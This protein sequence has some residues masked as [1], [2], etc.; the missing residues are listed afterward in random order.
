[1]WG[2]DVVAWFGAGAQLALGGVFLWAALSKTLALK[3]LREAIGGLGAPAGVTR[4]AA[5]AVV[6]VE[7]LTGVGLLLVPGSSVP[8][9]VV[10]LL[11]VGFAA[12]GGT[13]IVTKRRIAC[14]CFGSLGRGMLGRRQLAQFPLWLGLAGIA[15]WGTPVWSRTDGLL[16]LAFVLF[17]MCAVRLPGLLKPIRKLRADRIALAPSYQGTRPDDLPLPEK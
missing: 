15:E 6:A 5:P 11:A 10:V 14:N 3:G 16:V 13:A 7:C 8:R 4:L 1:M 12:A 2:T 17:G 9:A